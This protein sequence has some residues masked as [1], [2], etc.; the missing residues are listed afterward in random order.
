MRLRTMLPSSLLHLMLCVLGLALTRASEGGK[1]GQEGPLAPRSL[2]TMA[3]LQNPATA[4][5]PKPFA[6]TI[7][8]QSPP[9][10]TRRLE[11]RTRKSHLKASNNPDFPMEPNPDRSIAFWERQFPKPAD[12]NGK[13]P[14]RVF[15][16]DRNSPYYYKGPNHDRQLWPECVS[17]CLDSGI[18]VSLKPFSSC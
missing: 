12:P 1:D 17:C 8:R 9:F 11:Q 5:I 6:R 16:I 3:S 7:Q 13:L 15:G 10:G 4:D 18:E 2:T 14:F